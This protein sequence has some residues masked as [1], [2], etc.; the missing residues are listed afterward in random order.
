[1]LGI[2]KVIRVIKVIKE[3]ILIISITLITSS[4]FGQANINS[5]YSRYGVGDLQSEGFARNLGMGGLGIGMTSPFNVN[6]L[7]P[8]SYSSLVLTT[9]EGALQGN[10]TSLDATGVNSTSGSTS[11]GY[12]AF[13]FPIKA[14]KWGLSFGLLPYSSIGY[15]ITDAE[16]NSDLG[17]VNYTYQGK[18]GIN[19]FYVGTGYSLFKNFRVGVN[20]SYLFGTINEVRTVALPDNVYYFNT[21]TTDETTVGDFH[22]NFGLQYTLDSLKLSHSDSILMIRRRV[23]A[24]NQEINALKDSLARCEKGLAGTAVIATVKDSIASLKRQIDAQNELKSHVLVRR[25]RRD[26]S[27]NLGATLFL[28]SDIKVSKTSLTE[29]F[30]YSSDGFVVVKDTAQN[31]AAENGV[32]RLPLSVGYGFTMRKGA[33]WLFGADVSTQN[34]SDYRSFGVSDSLVNS[35]RYTI[36]AQYTP[37]ERSISSY[38]KVIQYRLGFHYDQTYLNLKNSGLNDYGV[39]IGFGLPMRKTLTVIH[40]AFEVGKMGTLV[41][42]LLEVNYFRFTLGLSLGDVWFLKPRVD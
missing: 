29:L 37:D 10:I 11:F 8:A 1:M 30:I 2:K 32:I 34:W 20:A 12:F 40:F 4:T 25:A 13:G 6:F 16:S 5:P 26:W 33:K 22:F 14:T 19:Q 38:L 15:N 35:M 31:I 28:A 27:L 9:F 41:N 24:I 7:N 42:Q 17:N 36:G 23:V 39:S 18:G 21:R 3:A